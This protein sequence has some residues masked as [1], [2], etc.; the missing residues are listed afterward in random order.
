MKP[1]I[2]RHNGPAKRPH[3][4]L[5]DQPPA[6]RVRQN[7]EADPGKGIL[8][9]LF[10]AQHVVVR[11]ML[12]AMRAQRRAKMFAQKFHA[13]ALDCIA[14][15][16]HPEQMNV[17]GHQAISRAKQTFARGCVEQH[18]P[19]VRV[20]IFVEP[21]R[22]TQRQGHRPMNDGAT[23]LILAREAGKIKIPIRSTTGK[24]SILAVGGFG[25]HT[26]KE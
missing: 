7:I 17:V 10:L 4:R 23:L 8:F 16:A 2:T 1:G 6:N 18:L 22:A 26:K 12:E 15:Q 24:A 9:A 21:A 20:E 14:A 3:F 5:L 19:E 11:L 25:F 13:V